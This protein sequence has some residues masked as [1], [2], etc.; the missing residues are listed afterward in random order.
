MFLLSLIFYF[1]FMCL[2]FAFI[3][4]QCF[5]SSYVTYS[6]VSVLMSVHYRRINDRNHTVYYKIK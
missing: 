6:F 3:L 5:A 4:F 2:Y 1:L